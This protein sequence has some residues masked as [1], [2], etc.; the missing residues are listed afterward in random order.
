MKNIYLRFFYFLFFIFYLFGCA[1]KVS[2]PLIY[3]DV[4]LSAE[5]IISITRGD[6]HSIK[7]IVNVHIEKDNIPY[8]HVD[9]SLLLKQPNWIQMRWYNFGLLTGSL[10]IKDSIVHA[11]SGKGSERFRDLGNELYY[12]V[13]WWDD[14]ENALMFRDGTEYVLRTE[15]RKIHLDSATLI[16]KKQEIIANNSSISI[17]YDRPG[18]NFIQT[19][20]NSPNSEAWFPSVIIIKIGSYRFSVKIDKLFFNPVLGEN[21][22]VVPGG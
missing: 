6:I 20:Q 2:P 4:E 11:A 22:F 19:V 5:E 8:S 3:K 12:S 10:V 16:P 14:L 7:A 18:K 1:P 15:K 21:D 13:F 17:T 9:A